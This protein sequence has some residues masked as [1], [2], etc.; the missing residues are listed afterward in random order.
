VTVAS[1]RLIDQQRH[2]SR[3]GQRGCA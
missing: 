3:S 1:R 2:P